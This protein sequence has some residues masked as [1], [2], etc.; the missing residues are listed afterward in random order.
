MRLS[1]QNTLPAS[2]LT[3]GQRNFLSLFLWVLTMGLGL[4]Q[5]VS[6]AASRPTANEGTLTAGEFTIRVTGGGFIGTLEVNLEV[7]PSST[8]ISGTD[9]SG[10][11]ATESV[12]I[13]LTTGNST[14]DIVPLQ[15]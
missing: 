10:I 12:T 2:L 5:T 3:Q 11:A 4:G 14:I 6:I 8:A 9:Y 15:D 7:D 1:L 13:F